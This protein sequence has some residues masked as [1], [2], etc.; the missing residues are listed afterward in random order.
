MLKLAHLPNVAGPLTRHNLDMY[1]RGQFK[2][3][4]LMHYHTLEQIAQ[5]EIE[6]P[7]GTYL[8]R[9]SNIVRDDGTWP[10]TVDLVASEWAEQ[11]LA[12]WPW[13]KIFQADNEVNLIA[14][15]KTPSGQPR[16]WY[17]QWLCGEII[18]ATRQKLT[19]RWQMQLA[20]SMPG[21]T[22]DARLTIIKHRQKSVQFGL[23]PFAY[24]P[25]TW[26]DVNERWLPAAD[27]LVKAGLVQR[28]GCNAYWQYSKHRLEGGFGGW[29]AHLHK[30]YPTLE[31]DVYE[32]G[33]SIAHVF[34]DW[35]DISPDALAICRGQMLE[36]YRPWLTWASQEPYLGTTTLYLALQG[37]REWDGFTP[38]TRVLDSISHL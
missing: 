37:T 5:L 31:M 36:D 35:Q 23:C 19:E 6:R 30:R 21:L 25:S 20:L 33:C 28:I 18:R 9:L 22:P 2:G 1:L 14:P 4:K 11:I 27:A 7:G 26:Q 32:W 34:E 12:V 38:D 24:N 15:L 29:P 3:A 8:K 13:C 16:H 17:W 10:A